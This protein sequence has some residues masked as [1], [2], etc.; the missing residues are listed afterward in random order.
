M[1]IGCTGNYR[2]EEY[3]TILWKIHKFLKNKDV[4][5][6][7]SSDLNK[8]KNRDK[9]KHYQLLEFKDLVKK[10]DIIFAIG[11]DGTILSTPALSTVSF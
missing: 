9:A 8:S 2:K 5:L 6:F 3:Y 7:V 10:C 1:L 4:E 11:G